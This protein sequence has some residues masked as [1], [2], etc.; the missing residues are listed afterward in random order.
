MKRFVTAALLAGMLTVGST[1]VALAQE[2]GV[3]DATEEATDDQGDTGL[4]GLAGLLGLLG[5]LGLRRRDD[6]ARVGS[7]RVR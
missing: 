5:L 3:E 1:S 7:D 2:T 4:I 6:R